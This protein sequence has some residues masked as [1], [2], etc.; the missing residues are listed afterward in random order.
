MPR[1]LLGWLL[2]LGGNAIGLLLAWAL[3]GSDFQINGI[4][5][6]VVSL[7]VFALL[8][9]FF[10]WLVFKGL[11]KKA[12]SVVPLTGVISTFLALFVTTLITDGLT[13]NGWGW[14][15]GTVIVWI[16]SMVIWAFPGPWRTYRSERVT[17]KGQ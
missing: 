4:L 8:S 6:F 17:G 14:V 11:D 3:L 16:L 1:F 7:V 12:A 10:T 15:W 5:G 2:G 13:I 9:A